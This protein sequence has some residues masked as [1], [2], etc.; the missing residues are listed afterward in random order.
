M[1]PKG[2]QLPILLLIMF[3]FITEIYKLPLPRTR[4]DPQT[5][6]TDHIASSS[7]CPGVRLILVSFFKI[8][9]TEKKKEEYLSKEDCQSNWLTLF[10][11]KVLKKTM[12][13]RIEKKNKYQEL[14]KKVLLFSRYLLVEYPV[15]Y[16]VLSL[17]DCGRKLLENVDILLS[18][19]LF[20]CGF[21]LS[22]AQ[23]RMLQRQ[24]QLVARSVPIM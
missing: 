5:T 16:A 2:K 19:K 7:H 24:S 14:K 12:K 22:F 17:C 1:I 23:L 21:R 9:S 15:P 6:E 8:P 18:L 10:I 20:S 11:K 3:W 4:S 13:M